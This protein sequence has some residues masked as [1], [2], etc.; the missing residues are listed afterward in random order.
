MLCPKLWVNDIWAISAHSEHCGT[1]RGSAH[2]RS[3]AHH[4]VWVLQRSTEDS[5]GH[6]RFHF[7]GANLKNIKHEDEIHHQRAALRLTGESPLWCRCVWER[8]G[9]RY[10]DMLYSTNLYAWDGAVSILLGH[11]RL[12]VPILNCITPLTYR[13]GNGLNFGGYLLD[14]PSVFCYRS[15]HIH[16]HCNAC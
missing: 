11:P 15:S 10:R 9:H 3:T 13:Q 8:Y 1:H 4:A 12:S 16:V 5:T 6:T 7:C 14:L 2:G